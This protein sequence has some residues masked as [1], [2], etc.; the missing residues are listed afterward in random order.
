[1]HIIRSAARDDI[2]KQFRY[3]LVDQDKPEV[4]VRFLVAVEKTIDSPAS[5]MR[6]AFCS[7][8]GASFATSPASRQFDSHKE[9]AAHTAPFC[10]REVEKP[11]EKAARG[12]GNVKQRKILC[13]IAPLWGICEPN[14]GRG[15]VIPSLGRISMRFAA[16]RTFA[17]EG[18]GKG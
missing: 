16:S 14:L 12:Y 4:A 15:T 10:L 1:M 7:Q 8:S 6:A 5:C 3:Y 11:V 9:V 18:L 17:V 13:L 2:L